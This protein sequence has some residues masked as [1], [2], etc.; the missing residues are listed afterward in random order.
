MGEDNFLTAKTS[1]EDDTKVLNHTRGIAPHEKFGQKSNLGFIQVYS[2]QP[3]DHCSRRM[4]RFG[5]DQNRRLPWR[6]IG[7]SRKT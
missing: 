1:F 6:N 7:N 3:R 4:S 5:K 2:G